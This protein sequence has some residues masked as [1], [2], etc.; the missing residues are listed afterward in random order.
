M[1]AFYLILIYF[2]SCENEFIVITFLVGNPLDLYERGL[3]LNAIISVSQH[4]PTTAHNINGI[5]PIFFC[6]IF[7]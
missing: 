2:R 4:S 7:K 5:I 3:L 6:E 1:T